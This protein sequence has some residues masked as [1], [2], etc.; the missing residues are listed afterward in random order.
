MKTICHHL[1]AALTVLAVVA[2]VLIPALPRLA[3]HAMAITMG[4]ELLAIDTAN[5]S[6]RPPFNDINTDPAKD[7]GGLEV[8]NLPPA[9]ALATP[10][11]YIPI[12]YWH[13]I[14][15]LTGLSHRPALFPPIGT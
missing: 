6:E 5:P 11:T 4:N 9:L 15:R 2:G 7:L 13:S 12:V 1:W 10:V 14:S 8:P 3:E